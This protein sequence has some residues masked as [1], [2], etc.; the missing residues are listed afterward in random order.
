M[1]WRAY[2]PGAIRLPGLRIAVLLAWSGSCDRPDTKTPVLAHELSVVEVAA[3]DDRDP[4]YDGHVEFAT[5]RAAVPEGAEAA[6]VRDCPVEAP[7]ACGRNHCCP[8]SMYCV[9]GNH[10]DERYCSNR[11]GTLLGEPCDATLVA[12]T[13]EGRLVCQPRATHT[14]WSGPAV[15][16]KT[17]TSHADCED[18]GVNRCCVDGSCHF[19]GP[20]CPAGLETRAIGEGQ[21]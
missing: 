6:D 2:V 3:L 17:C 21:D 4:S 19:L 9:S 11:A 16:T 15:C 5:E 8:A 14:G 10:S 1:G 18:A 20:E 7:L 12:T 13:C